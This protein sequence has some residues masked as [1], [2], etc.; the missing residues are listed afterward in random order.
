M[1]SFTLPQRLKLISSFR[2]CNQKQIEEIAE[3][4]EKEILRRKKKNK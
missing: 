3:M 2:A 1:K 4:V